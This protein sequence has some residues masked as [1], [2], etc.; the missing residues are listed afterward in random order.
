[1]VGRTRG[2]VMRPVAGPGAFRPAPTPAPGRVAPSERGTDRQD[3]LV[4]G[5][6]R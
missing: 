6:A 2:P 5:T 1:M 4:S 3:D